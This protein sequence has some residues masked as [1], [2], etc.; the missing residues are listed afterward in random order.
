MILLK[1]VELIEKEVKSGK[2]N[3][4]KRPKTGKPTKPNLQIIYSHLSLHSLLQIE[5]GQND[6]RKPNGQREPNK[7]QTVH[8]QFKHKKVE[9]DHNNTTTQQHKNYMYMMIGIG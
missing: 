7:Q 1:E 2:K 3:Q 4:L 9:H 5:K 6:Q 8:D